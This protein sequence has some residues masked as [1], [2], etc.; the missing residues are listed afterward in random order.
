M[1]G[2]KDDKHFSQVSF[3]IQPSELPS[4]PQFVSLWGVCALYIKVPVFT[5]LEE[6]YAIMCGRNRQ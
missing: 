2:V 4:G 3:K 5:A 6:G 1:D